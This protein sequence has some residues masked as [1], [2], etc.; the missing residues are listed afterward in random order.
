VTPEVKNFSF[1]M[2]GHYTNSKKPNTT[3]FCIVTPHSEQL[4]LAVVP[5]LVSKTLQ[6]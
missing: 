2:A 4:V 6:Y 3:R 5:V 1:F